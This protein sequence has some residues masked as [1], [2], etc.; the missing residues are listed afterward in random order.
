MSA[1][2]PA[3]GAVNPAASPS[4]MFVAGENSGDLHGARVIEHLRRMYP[5][6]NF[7]GF[8][9]DRMEKAG[10]VLEENLAQKL[11]IIGLTQV[12][13]NFPKIKELL[14]RAADMLRTRKPDLLVLID[15]PGFNLRTAAA[16]RELGV[17][18]VY[19]ISPQV[20]AWHRER[21]KIIQRNVDKM[22]VI[23]PFEA[24]MYQQE[25]ID[26]QYVGH[27]LQDD[28]TSVTPRPTVLKKL[29]I[30]DDAEVIGLMPGSRN[31]EIVRHLTPMLEAARLIQKR[32]PGVRFV[33]PRASTIA[34][35][36]LSKYLDR[37]PDVQVAI[38]EEDHKSV[39]AAMDFVICKSGT[40]T[41]E[42]A[43]LG[44]P[45]VIIYK[46]SWLTGFIARR[47]LKIPHIGLVNIVAGREVAPE[48]LQEQATGAQI[49]ERVLAILDDE[50]RLQDM[51]NQMEQVRETIG[52]PGASLRVA[53]A[54]GEFLQE[55]C[56]ILLPTAE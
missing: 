21:L 13:K 42:Y 32:K 50:K 20:W 46:A 47:V 45:M 17:P 33:L 12:I 44:V 19:Y 24:D 52:G 2:P 51:K 25:G 23:L 38:A 49:G 7:Y 30:A 9:G 34:P 41:L 16:A 5:G 6:G 40:S 15:Y 18:V 3:A 11:P 27:P 37:F 4:I 48:L 56:G 29:G 22:L 26:A 35:E 43:L 36:L 1:H 31:S 55:K 8:G 53:E 28:L 10:M 39:R 14:R 54:V